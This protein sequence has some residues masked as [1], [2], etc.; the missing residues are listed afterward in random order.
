MHQSNQKIFIATEDNATYQQLLNDQALPNLILTEHREEANIILAAP[1]KI[2]PQLSECHQLEWL[3]STYA[4]VNALMQPSLRRDYTL[5]NVRGIFGPLIAEYVMGYAIQHY[6]HLTLYAEQQQQ[7]IWQPHLYT[8]LEG[9]TVTILGTGSIGN[10]L[11]QVCAAMGLHTLGVNRTG[12]PPNGSHFH[13]T[14]HINELV[15]ALQQADIIVNTL[16]STEQTRH[17]LNQ[18]TLSHCRHA[19]LFNVG[20]GDAIDNAA[21]L[22]AIKNQ[23]IEHAFL[24]VFE[25]EPLVPEHPFWGLKPITITPHIAALSFPEKVIAL[26]AENYQRW[27]EGYPLNHQVSFAKGY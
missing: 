3:Q 10:H 5:T 18:D 12:I 14:Y 7:R 21:L 27:I 22:L 24:D 9:K 13:Q 26:F 6:R 19:L 2:A 17:L 4:G 16:P 23:W 20:R 8:S 11:A 15:A 25:Q 1:P